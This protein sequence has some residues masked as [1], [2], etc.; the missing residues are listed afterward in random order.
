MLPCCFDALSARVIASEGFPASLVSGFAVSGSRLGLPDTGLISFAEMRDQI[1]NICAAVPDML[2]IADGDTGFGNAINAQRTV[3]EYARSGVACVMIEDQVSP[4]RCGHTKGKG[5]VDRNEARV[6]I[7]ASVEAARETGVLIIARTDARGVLGLDEA[8]ERAR[9][10]AGE[11][12]DIIFVEAPESE[13]EMEQICRAA[14]QPMM[15]NMVRGG[16]TPILSPDRL[17]ELGF[18]LAVYPMVPFAASIHAMREAVKA[19]KDGS[20]M[21]NE[22]GFEEI[23]TLVGFDDYDAA[24]AKYVA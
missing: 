16:R 21:P 19:L 4:K 1:H 20:A 12:A 17:R 23:K 8:L 3:R 14:N 9:M 10:F 11:G 6:R 7:R 24:E 22:A 15:A 13:S 5:V 2:V 18:R